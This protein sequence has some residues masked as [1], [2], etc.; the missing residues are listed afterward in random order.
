MEGTATAAWMPNAVA[1][2]G[3]RVRRKGLEKFVAWSRVLMRGMIASVAD[4]PE[5]DG[6]AVEGVEGA[7]VVLASQ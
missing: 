4:N 5:D 1:T 7:S 6:D 3:T 2:E